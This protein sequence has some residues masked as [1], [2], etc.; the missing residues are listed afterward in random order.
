MKHVFVMEQIP[1]RTPSAGVPDGAVTGNGDL[2]MVFGGTPGELQFYIA[3]ADFWYAREGDVRS[4]GIRPAAAF[5]IS[6][7][8]LENAAW[9]VEEDLDLAEL[10][11]EMSGNGKK[12]NFRSIVCAGENTILFEISGSALFK[13]DM[14]VFSG[15]NSSSFDTAGDGMLIA[16]RSFDGPECLWPST[17]RLVLKRLPDHIEPDGERISRFVICSGTNH[18][19]P[20]FRER[21]DERARTFTADDFETRFVTHRIW[22]QEFYRKSSVKLPSMPDLELNWYAGQYFLA[23]TARNPHF[24]PGLYGNFITTDTPSWEGDYHLNYNYQAAFYAACSSNHIELTDGYMAP[25]EDFMPKGRKFA[26]EFLN[27]RGIYYPVGIGPRGLETSALW[28]SEENGHSFLGQKSNAIQAADIPVMRWKCEQD[29]QYAATHIYPYLKECVCFFMD[30]V[31]R[32]SDGKIRIPNDAAHEVLYWLQAFRKIEK[33]TRE[34]DTT[35]ILTLGLLKMALNTLLELSGKMDADADLRPLW[36]D[37]F[38]HLPPFPTMEH[39]GRNVFR[40]TVSGHDWCNGNAIALQHIYPCGQIG[41]DSG[42]KLLETAC[43]TFSANDRWLDGN[44]FSTYAP[45][46]ALIGIEPDEIIRGLRLVIEKLQLPN[47]MF[48]HPGGGMEN[49]P[50]IANTLNNMMLQCRA[51]EIRFFPDWPVSADA[52]FRHLRTEGAFLVDGEWRDGHF[53]RGRIFAEHGGKLRIGNSRSGNFI[54]RLNGKEISADSDF[55]MNA[56]DTAEITA[57]ILAKMRDI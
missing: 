24:P 11:G 4:G 21:T 15:G 31:Q 12:L 46:A 9:H 1:E 3:K 57:V 45:C 16:E 10:R 50:V 5:H 34:D 20:D 55:V 23:C 30:Y 19:G 43:N 14:T 38:N 41:F 25:L 7:P 48:A 53:L 35:P 40:L 27:C 8:D 54:L 42:E 29:L 37:F 39:N 18:E 13:N 47:G 36:Q 6:S 32:D 56:G 33:N 26:R 49:T 44:A 28:F 52:E 22:W 51:G 2:G 17:I